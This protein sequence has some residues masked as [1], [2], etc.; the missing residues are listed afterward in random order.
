MLSA[1]QTGLVI[2]GLASAA[3]VVLALTLGRPNPGDPQNPPA[4]EPAIRIVEPSSLAASPHVLFRHSA[5]DAHY[6]HMSLAPVAE[7]NSRRGVTSLQCERVSFAAGRGI[8][9][10]ADRGVF[11]KYE[12]VLFDDRFQPLR[13]MKLDGSP[14]RT[15]VSPDGRIGAITVFVTAQGHG[16]ATLGSFLTRTILLDMASGDV[17]GDLE[18]FSTWRDGARFTAKDFNFWGVTFARD[19]NTFYASL[20]SANNTYL[21]RGD[22]P[23]RRLT[24]VHENV[25]C[26]AISPNNRLIA[27]KKRVGGALRP[28]R[29][30]VLEL[31]T[32]TERPIAAETRSIDDQIEW[33]DD[34]HVLYATTR[35]S[36]SAIFDVWMAPIDG[37]TPAT[38]FL[39]MADSPVVA[40]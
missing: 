9:L 14:S 34:A 28:W 13:S 23:L 35:S 32:M 31:A 8:C 1:K 15:R 26:P 21:V 29:F 10:K 3:G 22:L 19:S 6:N 11:T 39:N 38:R 2:V 25:E 27:Y 16:Y 30:H 36:Q 5:S 33:Y 17:I 4:A 18:Q 12:A 40:R 37:D 20:Q 7:P 24:V